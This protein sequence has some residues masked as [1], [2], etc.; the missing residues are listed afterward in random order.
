MSIG[1]D[2]NVATCVT[3]ESI[4]ELKLLSQQVKDL[5]ARIHRIGCVSERGRALENCIKATSDFRQRVQE[6]VEWLKTNLNSQSFTVT[7][8]ED[9]LVLE[10]KHKMT[11]CGAGYRV[12]KLSPD[13][14][15]HPCPLMN[16][17][18]GSIKKISLTDFIKTHGLKFAGVKPPSA[19]ICGNCEKLVYC[20][21]C[22]AEALLHRNNNECQ[23]SARQG[24]DA[25]FLHTI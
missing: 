2:V 5:G 9:N 18:I 17:P 6:D 8:F 15:I 14:N 16:N 22:M 7:G 20:H 23:W 21:D 24:I 1:L 12:L 3:E 11:N 13:G 10:N 4:G 25:M 19:D